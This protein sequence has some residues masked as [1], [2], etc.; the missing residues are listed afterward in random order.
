MIE[1]GSKV[2]ARN[3][4]EQGTV[5]RREFDT[6]SRDW[7]YDVEWVDGTSTRVPFLALVEV[8]CAD[9]NPHVKIDVDRAG[10]PAVDKSTE[11]A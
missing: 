6:W 1:P 8:T 11:G 7:F 10:D 2:A 5:T 4:D 9:R 3:G